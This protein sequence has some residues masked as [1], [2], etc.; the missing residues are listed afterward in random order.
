VVGSSA[1]ATL[2]RVTLSA[3][4]EYEIETSSIPVLVLARGVAVRFPE[5]ALSAA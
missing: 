4:A 2:G 5:P 1:G 3:A